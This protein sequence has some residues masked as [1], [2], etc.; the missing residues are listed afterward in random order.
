MKKIILFSMFLLSGFAES[1]ESA[2]LKKISTGDCVDVNQSSSTIYIPGETVRSFDDPFNRQINIPGRTTTVD[3]DS[4]NIVLYKGALNKCKIE[5]DGK[6]IVEKLRVT[7][8]GSDFIVLS[9]TTIIPASKIAKIEL[10]SWEKLSAFAINKARK[11]REWEKHFSAKNGD[12]PDTLKQL[13]EE[14]RNPQF[15][16]KFIKIH[17]LDKM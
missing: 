16:K 1:A 2:L 11:S 9:E 17:L 8:V 7:E 10:M 5:F 13:D 6:L 3:H 4:F 14:G 12:V 15:L